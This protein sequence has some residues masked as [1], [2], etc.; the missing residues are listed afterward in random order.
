MDA[1]AE[2]ESAP[3]TREQIEERYEQFIAMLA[4]KYGLSTEVTKAVQQ[5]FWSSESPL[6][7]HIMT[8][9]NTSSASMQDFF[10]FA[11]TYDLSEFVEVTDGE[12]NK[13]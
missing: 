4:E 12:K 6:C 11:Q 7:D 1:V 13:I 8:T 9:L 10:V 2:V 5:A 3:E